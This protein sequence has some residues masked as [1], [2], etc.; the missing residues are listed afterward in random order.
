MNQFS[1]VHQKITHVHLVE[2]SPHLRKVQLEMLAPNKEIVN[3]TV[4]TTLSKMKGAATSSRNV[5]QETE[6]VI[7]VTFRLILV[8]RYARFR[9]KRHKLFCSSRIF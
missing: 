5:V 4:T 1:F 2:A 6:I 8:A 3:D 9:S 7:Q